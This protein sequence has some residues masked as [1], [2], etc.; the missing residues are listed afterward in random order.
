M[1]ADQKLEKRTLTDRTADIGQKKNKHTGCRI[2]NI[3][4][5]GQ[6]KTGSRPVKLEK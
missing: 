4:V 2:L 6:L 3:V 5:F 1:T